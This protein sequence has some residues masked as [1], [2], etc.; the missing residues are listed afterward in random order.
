MAS[1][2]CPHCG[3][4]LKVQ[5][6]SSG[7]RR[8]CSGCGRSFEIPSVA[9]PSP[10]SPPPLP[11]PPSPPIPIPLH[12]QQRQAGRRLPSRRILTGAGLLVVAV[13]VAI[14]LRPSPPVVEAPK[15]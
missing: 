14:M 2:T 8:K 3:K 5:D 1:F 9:P 12:H 4:Q 6:G 13:L 10:P 15:P 7:R 11:S